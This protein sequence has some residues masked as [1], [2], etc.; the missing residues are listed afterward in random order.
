MHSIINDI[1]YKSLC[2]KK[3]S[4]LLYI[5]LVFI[6]DKGDNYYNLKQK[7]ISESRKKYKNMTTCTKSF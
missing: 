2:A 4:V 3:D 6:I 7:L 5:S 1:L